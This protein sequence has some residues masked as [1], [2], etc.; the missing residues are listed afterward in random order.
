MGCIT[1]LIFMTLWTL[2]LIST[3]WTTNA[4]R[5]KIRFLVWILWSI[6]FTLYLATFWTLMSIAYCGSI[7]EHTTT[8]SAMFLLSICN[9]SLLIFKNWN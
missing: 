7:M 3:F 1:T 6:A 5:S 4:S 2:L 9:L 8:A